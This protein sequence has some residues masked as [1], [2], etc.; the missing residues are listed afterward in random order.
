MVIAYLRVT[1]DKKHLEKQKLEIDTY[2]TA[3]DIKIDKWVTDVVDIKRKDNTLIL[4][5]LITRMKKGDKLIITDI[6]RLGRTLSEVM[7]ILNKCMEKGIGIYSLNDRYILDDYLDMQVIGKTCILIA[8]IEHH[9]MSTRT[10]EALAHKKDKK[11]V[12]LGRP[13]GTDAKQ[14]VLKSH[15]EE[16]MNMLERGDTVEMICNHFNV[17]RNTY[18]QFKRNYG[19]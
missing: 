13:K 6:A 4:F 12:R 17:S 5:Q 14:A 16:V 1:K 3:H 8:D 7:G 2:V 11:G 19:L 9:L 10:K 15:K 18:Y